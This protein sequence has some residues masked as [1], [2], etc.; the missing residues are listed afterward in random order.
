[1][2]KRKVA[3]DR[4]RRPARTAKRAQRPK[5]A[6][7]AQH[8]KQ[9][10]IRGRKDSAAAGFPEESTEIYQEPKAE[11]FVADNRARAAALETILQSSLQNEFDP[12]IG[13]GIPSKGLGVFLPFAN[14]QAYQAKLLEMTHANTQFA[15]ELIL[16]LAKIRSPFEFWAVIAEFT[17]RRIM[18]IGKDSKEL[19]AFW[20]TDPIRDLTAL[21]GR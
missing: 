15:F 19:A 4:A 16:R 13:S 2:S 6:A 5:A 12:K 7:R 14:M 10:L 8:K 9:A 20:R 21:P 18:T 1:M 17:A 11:P 3:T